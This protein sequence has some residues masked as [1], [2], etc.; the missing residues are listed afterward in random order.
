[1]SFPWMGFR[2]RR[3]DDL[4]W[5]GQTTTG[6]AIDIPIDAMAGHDDAALLGGNSTD[7]KG[8]PLTTQDA[9]N[10]K[11]AVQLA[12]EQ[13]LDLMASDEVDAGSFG[14]D[15]NVTDKVNADAAAAFNSGKVQSINAG[16]AGVG[17]FQTEVVD[18]LLGGS[19]YS[20]WLFHR[21]TV[22]D[23]G[24]SVY[25]SHRISG[26]DCCSDTDSCGCCHYD[27]GSGRPDGPQ[28]RE[29]ERPRAEQRQCRSCSVDSPQDGQAS[30]LRKTR[31]SISLPPS[32]RGAAK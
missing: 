11:K 29:R 5:P 32:P 25:S 23:F 3:A 12:I 16:N 1:M 17:F 7:P 13:A 19:A 9:V 18:S 14:Q 24:G 2:G 27:G 10:L 22:A 6:T 26:P 31:L 15:E 21:I 8:F 28:A 30:P 4:A 20:S